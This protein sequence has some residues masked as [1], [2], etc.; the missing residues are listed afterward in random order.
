MS[1]VDDYEFT[2]ILRHLDPNYAATS[3]AYVRCSKVKSS[4]L[5]S[6]T[7]IRCSTHLHLSCKPVAARGE[8]QVQL[9]FFPHNPIVAIWRGMAQ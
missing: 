1:G 4:A 3:L 6:R 9:L 8:Y 5:S 7:D 2:A